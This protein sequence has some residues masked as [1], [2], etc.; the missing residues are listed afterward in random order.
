[1]KDRLVALIEQAL[2]SL[3]ANGTLP[4]DARRPVQIDRTKDKSHGDFATNIALMLAKPAGLKPRDLAQALVDALPEDKAVAKVEIAGPGFINFFQAESWLTDQLE[5]ALADPHLAVPRPARHQTVVI[6]YSSPNLA[7][8]MHVGH[9]RSTI[10]GD[11]V[12][13]TLDFLGHKVVP[14]NH[15]GDWGTQFGMLLAYLEERKDEDGDQALNRELSD[16]ETFYRAAKQRFDESDQF[17]DRA[18]ALVVKL[19]SGDDYCLKLWREFNQVSLSHCFAVYRRLGVRLGPDDVRGESAYND[20]LPKVV[21]DLDAAG[22]LTEDQGARCVFL[23]EF[24]NKDG[25][26]LPVIVQKAGGG[27]LYAT[28]DLAAVRYRAGSWAATACCISWINAR[29]CTSS[30]FSRWPARPASWTTTWRWST[31]ASAP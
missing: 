15:V 19:Q 20:D 1:M 9:L 24:R 26:T 5:A 12:V 31:W 30:R 28:T 14:Q 17:A 29:P 13:R 8:E 10:I 2:E 25:D 4:A 11:A 16:L 3:T 21:A 18:R 22:L 23:D 6:D 27:Y 7:K